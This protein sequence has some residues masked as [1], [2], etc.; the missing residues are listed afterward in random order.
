MNAR[1]MYI[2][3]SSRYISLGNL[4]DQGQP[5]VV[6]IRSCAAEC[7]KKSSSA[8]V[9]SLEQTGRRVHPDSEYSA[10][11]AYAL[12]TEHEYPTNQ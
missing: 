2:A 12:S 8:D 4:A 6:D 9:F 10:G 1:E 3:L 5:K 7:D 11:N